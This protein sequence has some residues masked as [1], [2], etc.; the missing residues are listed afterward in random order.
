M[1]GQVVS[2]A[3]KKKLK[4][5]DI[6]EEADELEKESQKILREEQRQKLQELSGNGNMKD[7]VSA[8]LHRACLHSACS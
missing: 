7:H 2:K 5:L 4:A 3:H 1:C 6:E 8:A